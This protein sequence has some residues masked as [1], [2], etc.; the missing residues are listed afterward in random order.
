MDYV[1]LV[2]QNQKGESM[3]HDSY[4][5]YCV[6]KGKAYPFGFKV[7]A[8]FAAEELG[9]KP[10]ARKFKIAVNTL[11]SWINEFKKHG[12][13]GLID[14]R[15]GPN[16]IPHKTPADEEEKIV[17]IRTRAPCFGPNRI[18]YFYNVSCSV[19]AIRRIIRSHNLTRKPKKKQEKKRD[20][21]AVK[22]KRA[23]M[24]YLQMDVKYLTDI[25]N[26]W[27]QIKPLNL[28]NYQ[29]TVRD[30]KSG[31]LFLGYSEELSELNAR[32]MVDYVISEMKLD[33]PFDI[34]KLNVQTDN[35]SEF[36]G[37]AR[38]VETA[39]FVHMIEKTHGA[40]HNYIRPGHCNANA[41]VESLHQTIEVEFFDLVRFKDRED[42]LKK[43]ESYRLYYNFTRPNFS[44]GGKTPQ[45]ICANDWNTSVSYNF[46]L[47]KTIDLDKIS[48][49]SYQRCQSL[50]DSTEWQFLGK[51]KVK[52]DPHLIIAFFHGKM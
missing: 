38:R 42:F 22:A 46:S 33:L 43:I 1:L 47:I 49:F 50:P 7:D 26:Y 2:V 6:G 21:R 25:P 3:E 37:L 36:S 32:T 13:K 51:R 45:N 14:K 35:G 28:P 44:K 40:N 34:K 52:F 9:K 29:Y 20:L 48:N 23:S 8:V 10:A 24:T 19:G 39:P 12:K 18:K 11:K 41:D 5:T 17:S 4:L 30:S 15:K 31:M 16:F 27:E